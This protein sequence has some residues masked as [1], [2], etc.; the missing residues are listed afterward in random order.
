MLNASDSYTIDVKPCNTICSPAF[1]VA[2]VLFF[3]SHERRCFH[4]TCSQSHHVYNTYGRK[5]KIMQVEWPL[6][7]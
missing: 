7:E 2:N 1:R 4:L 5:F 6:V 3:H